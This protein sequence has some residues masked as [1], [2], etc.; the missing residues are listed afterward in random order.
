VSGNVDL[1]ATAW[2]LV[3][4]IPGVLLTS[5]FTVRLPDVVLRTALG[6]VL[7]LS[8]IKLLNVPASNWILAAG[9]ASLVLGLAAYG[10][11]RWL[12]STRAT[13]GE[14]EL[15]PAEPV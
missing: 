1:H 12:A 2:L 3:G 6:S 13:V 7:I 14:Q 11:H 8:G 4:S 5:R 9:I 15:Q 10:A